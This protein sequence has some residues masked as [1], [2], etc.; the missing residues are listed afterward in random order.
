[1]CNSMLNLYHFCNL[2]FC[3]FFLK[4]ILIK[5]FILAAKKYRHLSQLVVKENQ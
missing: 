2:K 1:M 4:H 5:P 3:V